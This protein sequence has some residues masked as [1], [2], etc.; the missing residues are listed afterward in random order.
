MPGPSE[1]IGKVAAKMK[2][3]GSSGIYKRLKED[4]GEV[5]ALMKRVAAS[6][7]PDTR[8]KFFPKVRESLLAHSKAEDK[9][10][11]APLFDQPETR[12]LIEHSR[13]DHDEIERL[14]DALSRMDAA[15]DAWVEDFKRLMHA[16]EAH[17]KVEENEVFP[18]AAGIFSDNQAKEMERRFLEEKKRFQHTLS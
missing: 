18:K 4:H 3:L 12:G 1:V 8:R 2:G 15:T 16:V 10:F 9:E 7:D 13:D 11:Y 17:V 14:L 6:S 5:S